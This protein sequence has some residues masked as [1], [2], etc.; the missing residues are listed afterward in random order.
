MAKEDGMK[1]VFRNMKK[2]LEEYKEEYTRRL[3]Y[4]IMD[5]ENEKGTSNFEY[6]SISFMAKQ[7]E[8]HA[9]IKELSFWIEMMEGVD[10]NV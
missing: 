7:N 10:E 3:E 1:I 8:L 5:I 4:Y 6:N 9:K 2:R